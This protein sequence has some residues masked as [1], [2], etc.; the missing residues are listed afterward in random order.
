VDLQGHVLEE[1]PLP[2]YGTDAVVT[3]SPDETQ[4]VVAAKSIDREHAS[5]KDSPQLW[6][7]D[8]KRNV[9][10]RLTDTD[11]YKMDASWTA[12]GK[13]IIYTV[14]NTGTKP[15]VY[16]QRADGSSAPELLF[17]NAAFASPTGDGSTYVMAEGPFLQFRIVTATADDPNTRTVFQDS[18]EMD[19][20]P[21][22]R[23]GGDLLAYASGDMLNA[24]MRLFLRRFPVGSGRWQVFGKR[25]MPITWSRTG[26]RLYFMGG[27][28]DTPEYYSVDVEVAGDEVQ[29][30]EPIR[31]L[32]ELPPQARTSGPSGLTMDVSS[33]DK[34]LLVLIQEAT[35][36]EKQQER[37]GITLVEHWT[38]LLR[39]LGGR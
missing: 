15:S 2:F 28:P 6:I 16:V 10:T 25:A 32:T 34:R 13:S 36:D 7:V 1:L 29:L 12:D 4:A 18:T 22:P 39:D 21:R 30:A 17:E 37:T 23:P 20:F 8:L 24:E 27:E 38:S 9:A 35:A 5:A 31:I 26:N 3:L 19:L 11:G 14:L 33:D